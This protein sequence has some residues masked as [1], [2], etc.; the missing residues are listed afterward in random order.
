MA[1]NSSR[2]KVPDPHDNTLK[3]PLCNEWLTEDDDTAY[4]YILDDTVHLDC[5]MDFDE[6]GGL[7]LGPKTSEA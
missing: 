3:C 2:D 4:S 7:Y 6:V 5:L 1:P